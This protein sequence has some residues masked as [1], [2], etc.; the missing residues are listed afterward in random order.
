MTIPAGKPAEKAVAARPGGL[1]FLGAWLGCLYGFIEAFEVAGL[2]LV[3]GALSWRTGNS[4]DILWFAP[5]FYTLV[6]TAVAGIFAV[7]AVLIRRVPWDLLLVFGYVIAGAYLAGALV[8]R[9]VADWALAIF[10]LGVAVQGARMYWNRRKMCAGLARRSLPFMLV[11]VAVLWLAVSGAVAW[12][13]RRAL[14]R[15]PEGVDGR[16]NVL[17]LVIDTQRADHLSSYGYDRPTT[18]RLDALAGEGVL[19][20]RAF[21]SSPWTLPTHATFFTERLPHEH[22]AGVLGRPYLDARFPTLA[23]VL[24]DVGYATGGFVANGYWCGRQTGIDRGFIHYED[25]YGN[26]GDAVAR[27]SLGRWFA[28]SVRPKFGG[29]DILGRKR[30]A[31]AN[32]D[33]LDWL[34]GIGDR[35]F[36]AFVNYFDVHGPF[37]PPEPYAGRFSG[38]TGAGQEDDEIQIGALTGD[39]PT[40]TPEQVQAMVDAY[41]ES[42]LYVDAEIGA[43]VDTLQARGVLDNTVLVITSDHGESWGEHGMMFHGHSLYLDQVLAPLIVRYPPAVPQGIR[44]RNAVGVHQLPRTVA[45]LAGVSSAPFSAPALPLGERSDVPPSV[46]LAGVSRRSMVPADWPTSRGWVAAAM[47]ERWHYILEESGDEFLFDIDADPDEVEN[48]ADLDEHAAM[49]AM[50]RQHVKDMW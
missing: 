27:T 7:L 1:V 13:E 44:V 20:E 15:L 49:V 18:P 26:L 35:P 41:D 39:M 46:V 31:A 9:V 42:L 4:L 48:L 40:F 21:A 38:G 10:A 36:F 11:G 30:A 23:E 24:R 33:L 17:L 2:G 25:F 14:A 3:P 28:Y 16:P 45:D 50:F 29:V 37:V 6:G 22:R 19:Y 43:L 47:T 8:G 5:L 32:R 12:T 34:D